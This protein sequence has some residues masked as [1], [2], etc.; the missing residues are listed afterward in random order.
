MNLLK[1]LNGCSHHEETRGEPV[2]ELNHQINVIAVPREAF[3]REVTPKD[4]T[5]SKNDYHWYTP[6]VSFLRTAFGD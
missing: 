2:N 4:Y 6:L 5:P 3:R 1:Y